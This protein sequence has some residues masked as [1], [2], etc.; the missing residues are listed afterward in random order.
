MGS[1]GSLKEIRWLR[2]EEGAHFAKCTV[3][4]LFVSKNVVPTKCT[5]PRELCDCTGTITWFLYKVYCT[6]TITCFLYKMYCTGTITWFLYKVYCTG[7]INWFLQSVLCRNY[8]VV[9]TKCTVPRNYHVFVQSV[10]YWNYHVF[11]TEF[12]VLEL[13]RGS[14]KVYCSP[15]LSRVSYKVY[16][17]G[18]IT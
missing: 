12:T 15:E 14:Y 4:E 3:L 9:S 7:T 13:S 11:P 1:S 6:G 8:N 18:T 5:V 2:G 17:T 10:L 16:W